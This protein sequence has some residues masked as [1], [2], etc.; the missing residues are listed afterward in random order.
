MQKLKFTYNIYILLILIFFS[1]LMVS[2]GLPSIFNHFHFIFVIFF[3]YYSIL[4]KYEKNKL[5]YLIILYSFVVLISGIINSSSFSN[6][7]IYILITS[8]PF[9]IFYIFSIFK[10]ENKD[11]NFF[12]KFIFFVIFFNLFLIYY[13]Y[14]FLGLRN[15]E[16]RGVFFNL[17]SGAHVTSAVCTLLALY[18]WFFPIFSYKIFNYLIVLILISSNFLSDAKQNLI[19]YGLAFISYYVFKSFKNKNFYGILQ[20]LFYLT[21]SYLFINYLN[22]NTNLL[23]EY[24]IRNFQDIVYGFKT[25]FVVYDLITSN[26]KD[27]FN[28]LFG[29]GPGS[30]T[31]KLARMI[32]DYSNLSFLNLTGTNLTNEIF[33]FQQSNY[34]TA[35]TTGSSIFNL[36]FFWPSMFGDVGLITIC[37]YI[38]IWF[39][40]LK[41][42]NYDAFI[43]MLIF[44][45][46]IKGFFFD[47]PEEPIFST[48]LILI[49]LL[50]MYENIS[51]SQ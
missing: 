35:T 8:E 27:S 11:I 40:I 17:G 22:N 6:I 4:Y 37:I 2:L 47:W 34:I 20:I 10:L 33:I 24:K 28:F 26:F 16:V 39:H 5:L 23:S 1:R 48:M 46:F 36:F 18:F 31:S 12:K 49:I 38:Y 44:L 7:I 51:N 14:F 42:N 9:L 50:R 32:P 25:K 43:F 13:Q 15:D 41:K 30:T 45:I 21:I 29:L 3:T 19:T